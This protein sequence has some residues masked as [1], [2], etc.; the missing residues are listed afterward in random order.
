M[1]IALAAPRRFVIINTLA[2]MDS[3]LLFLGITWYV[4]FLLSTTCHE[5]AHGYVAKLGG[6]FTAFHGGQVSLDPL[7]HIRREPFGMV[8]FP[9]LTFMTS[10]WMMGWASAPYDP[11]WALIY[12]RR[13]AWMSLAGPAANLTLAI[14][15]AIGIRAGLFLGV[16]E[17]PRGMRFAHIVAATTPGAMEGAATLLSVLFSLNLLLCVFNLLPLPPL[18]GFGALGVFFPERIARKL[19]EFG[20]RLRGWSIV[21]LLIAWRMFDQVFFPVFLTAMRMLYART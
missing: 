15:G 5:A 8:I 11:R 10:G 6:D 2:R 13:S 16:F 1:H 3:N 12:P 19:V 14:I 20:F 9:I 18:D 4:V 17:I 7:P 21:G